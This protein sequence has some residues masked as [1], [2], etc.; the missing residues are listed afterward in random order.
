MSYP[1]NQLVGVNDNQTIKVVVEIAKGSSHKIEWNRKQ[2]YFVLD[3][4]EPVIFVKPVN[5]G[6]IPQTLD[7]D[8]DELDALVVTEEPLPTGI[9]VDQATVLGVLRFVDGGE[10]D[11]KIICVPTDDRHQQYQT[12]AD[13][14]QK[15]QQQITHHFQ[16]YKDLKKPGTTQVSGFGDVEEAW[17][18]IQECRQRALAQPWW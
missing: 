14:G 9:V 15:W 12:L 8:N 11:H 2:G 6:F 18:V 10:N 5:Y 7:E 16:H 17:A 3:R 1:F 13:L 4:V